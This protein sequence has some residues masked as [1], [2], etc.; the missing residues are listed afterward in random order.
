VG[1]WLGGTPAN[2]IHSG[3]PVKISCPA[4]GR[5]GNVDPDAIVM[6]ARC[7]KCNASFRVRDAVVSLP[8]PK[9]EGPADQ[10]PR[11]VFLSYSSSD[12]T[13]AES[14]CQR[15]EAEHIACWMAP[16][17]VRPG[18]DYGEAILNGLQSAS[19]LVLIFSEKSNVSKHVLREVERSVHFGKTILLFRIEECKPTK[20]LE[21]FLSSP[22][23]LDAF[24]GSLEDHIK[25]L[26]LLLRTMLSQDSR[27]PSIASGDNPR[28]VA[29]SPALLPAWEKKFHDGGMAE[30]FDCR[31][32]ILMHDLRELLRQT[33]A[34]HDVDEFCIENC[35]VALV[36]LYRNASRHAALPVARVE[37]GLSLKYGR[38][39]LSVSSKGPAFSL[40]EALAKYNSL[41]AK[42]R[43]IHGLQNLLPRGTLE[44]SHNAGWN[45]VKF[46]TN[47][48]M[49]QS[50]PAEKICLELLRSK[51]K[52]GT[53]VYGLQ[54]WLHEIGEGEP[55]HV[56][57][58]AGL[59]L[60][61]WKGRGRCQVVVVYKRPTWTMTALEVAAIRAFVVFVSSLAVNNS[62]VLEI[63]VTLQNELR[64]SR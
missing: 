9:H 48:T 50:L 24:T 61:Q 56:R 35:E 7:K 27:P 45:T 26:A 64:S 42:Q 29:Y 33:L 52:L 57:K 54:A 28:P 34:A 22:H 6:T 37:I 44:L 32:E 59:L 14:V 21:Y 11:A 19:V 38:F 25:Q 2:H 51:V 1:N 5:A 20:S 53:R 13:V 12:R 15:I 39:L 17:D 8:S 30:V 31:D 58:V 16:R 60:N 43:T 3:G 49:H 10:I 36:E 40:E 63:P 23:W 47:L 41:P 46:S 62:F 4:C 18:Q 55:E